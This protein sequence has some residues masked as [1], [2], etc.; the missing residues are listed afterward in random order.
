MAITIGIGGESGSGKTTSLKSIHEGN[1]EFTPKN[2]FYI[3][4]D[5]KELPFRN[6][7]NVWKKELGNYLESSDISSI[8]TW[9]K[10]VNDKA[11]HIR[12]VII[13]TINGIMMDRE[14]MESRS[15]NYDKWYDLAKDIYEL[16]SI[17]NNEMRSDLMI[18]FMTHIA[19]YTDVDGKEKKC[20][21][22]NGR[23]LEKIR[24]ES[25]LPIM[26]YTYVDT[27][28]EGHNKYMFQVKPINS[29]A[30]TPLEM[31]QEDTITVPND[32]NEVLKII[33]NFYNGEPA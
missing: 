11:P 10:K 1:G 6:W 25:K 20:I 19:L 30:K 8:K 29:T 2:V 13:D 9:L 28:E 4:A 33:D 27:E 15:L 7:R 5:K 31:Y 26:I 22:T 12:A 23:K 24:L 18:V 16:I 17:S 21:V 32:L 3:N 14:M